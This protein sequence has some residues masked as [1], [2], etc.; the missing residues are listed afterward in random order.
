M[1]RHPNVTR[2]V[3]TAC[4]LLHV[5]LLASESDKLTINLIPSAFFRNDASEAVTRTGPGTA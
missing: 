4:R 1:I 2:S 3:C 5:H